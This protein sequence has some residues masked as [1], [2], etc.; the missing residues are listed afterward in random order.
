MVL[1]SVRAKGRSSGLPDTSLPGGR[2]VA[3]IFGWVG[4]TWAIA[5]YGQ[6]AGTSAGAAASPTTGGGGGQIV[7]PTVRVTAPKIVTP[8]PGVTIQREQ[9]TTNVQSATAKDL[10]NAKS[11]SL[12]DFMNSTMQS[13]SVN[14]YQGNPFQQDLVFRGF[15][16]SPL[17]GTP[18][19]L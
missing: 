8:I 15:A 1:W 12:T 9:T 2:Q 11:V 5:S 4:L 18:Q 14:D 3:K 17:I 6:T 10:D 16:A 7:A 13:V 19:G